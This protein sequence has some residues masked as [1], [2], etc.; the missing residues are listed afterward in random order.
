MIDNQ[1]N[2]L[3]ILPSM[4]SEGNNKSGTPPTGGDRFDKTKAEYLVRLTYSQDSEDEFL[5]RAMEESIRENDERRAA[6]AAAAAEKR[7]AAA[8]KSTVDNAANVTGNL[9]VLANVSTQPPYF[10]PISTIGTPIDRASAGVTPSTVGAP[11][12]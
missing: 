8:Q 1:N 6:A 3:T 7:A 5:A 11:S 10:R 2:E 4:E 12:A 9:N